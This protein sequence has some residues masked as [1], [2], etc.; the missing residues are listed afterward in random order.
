MKPFFLTTALCTVATLATADPNPLRNAYFGETHMHTAFSLDAYIGGTRLMPADSLAFAKGEAVT[1]PDGTVAQH[2]RPLDFAAVTDH[3]EYI[4]E[5]YSTMFE[6]APGHDNEDLVALRGLT[7]IE[8]RQNWFIKYVVSSNRSATPQ[9]PPFFAGPAT[10]KSAWQL[11]VE[12]AE[13]A[14]D[15]GNFTALIGFEWSAAPNGAN[16]HRNVLFRDDNVPASVPSYIDINEEENLWAWM[17]A[18]ESEGRKLLAIPH[19]SNASK[20]RMFPDTDSFG[21]AMDLDYARTRQYYEPL[22]EMMQ[23]KGNSEVHRKFWAADEFAGFENA[24]SIQKN[25]GRIFRQRDFVRGGLIE[26][27]SYEFALGVNP[28][29]YGFMGGTDNHNGLMSAVAEDSFDGAHGPEDG[30][31]ERRRTGSVAGWI[32]GQDLSIG[33]IGGVWATENTRAAI[34]DAMKRRETFATSGPRIKVRMF[35]GVGLSDPSDPI[36]MAEEG[37]LLGTPMGGNLP[38]LPS[39]PTF[40]V[41]AEKD[42]QGANLDRIQII[43]GWVDIYGDVNEKIID[44]VW[45]GARKID[46]LTGKLSPVG[47]TVD[48]ATAMFTNDIGGATLAGSWTDEDFDPQEN[49]FYY[50]RVIE[51]PTPRWSTYDAVRAGLPLLEDV[52]ATIQERAWGSPIWYAPES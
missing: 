51:I 46:P 11:I 50:P 40:T 37:Y 19:N 6:D 52:P 21:N 8:E 35:G 3:A 22:I 36:A 2:K 16:L 13:Q 38:S 18:Q 45:S 49:A 29:K 27:I 41:Y 17:K 5:M 15:P 39:A 42:P 10:A 30:S 34:W 24:D 23:V 48:L 14:N 20:G 7:D 4:G 26:G 43:K 12:A 28:F 44:V 47:N 1:L 9:H 25:S 32:D 33:S 31:V